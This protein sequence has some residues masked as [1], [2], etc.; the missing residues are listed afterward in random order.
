[1]LKSTVLSPKSPLLTWSKINGAGEIVQKIGH[2]P[3]VTLTN[4]GSIPVPLLPPELCQE[5]CLGAEP[6]INPD[7]HRIWRKT[8]KNV[9]AYLVGLCL[10]KD[11]LVFA[12]NLL[13]WPYANPLLFRKKNNCGFIVGEGLVVT[14]K[15]AWGWGG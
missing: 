10:F 14:L 13:T 15:G 9:S 7:H 5:W 8:N 4:P 12:I 1:M 3:Y 11:F 2:W 6:R